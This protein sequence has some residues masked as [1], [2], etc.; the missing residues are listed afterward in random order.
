MIGI[1]IVHPHM[2]NEGWSWTSPAPFNPNI[3]GIIEDPIYSMKKIQEI[4]LKSKPDYDQRLTVPILFDR[5]HETIVNNES[6]EILRML[7]SS[8]G[9]F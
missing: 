7:N 5:K 4:Y 9:F 6:S 8:V 2:G 3:S 1:S